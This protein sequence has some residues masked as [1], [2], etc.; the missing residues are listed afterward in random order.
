MW[1][2]VMGSTMYQLGTVLNCS[3]AKPGDILG[4]VINDGKFI[5]L[6]RKKVKQPFFLSRQGAK[7]LFVFNDGYN[8]IFY[9]DM[10]NPF[11]LCRK[12]IVDFIK[13]MNTN[14]TLEKVVISETLSSILEGTFKDGDGI[15]LKEISMPCGIGSIGKEAFKGV[16][17]IVVEYDG[18]EL[19]E[20]DESVFNG[21]VVN[22]VVP[23]G[24][25][26]KDN[27]N[28]EWEPY[29]REI[30]KLVYTEK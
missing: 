30:K 22:L 12:E 27:G 5:C 14:N 11:T 2:T 25:S 26:I 9:G 15:S 13:D 8:A 18:F 28:A 1:D 19:P 24:F 17:D 6:I 20:I 16:K 21:K 10:S 7:A 23:L 3:E 4:P 29:V